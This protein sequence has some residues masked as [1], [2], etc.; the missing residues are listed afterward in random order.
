MWFPKVEPSPIGGF[1]GERERFCIS[2]KSSFLIEPP[3]NGRDCP[4]KKKVPSTGWMSGFCI[5]WV[6][7]RGSL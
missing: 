4:L 2:A 6:G 7:L 1:E 5:V 3:R